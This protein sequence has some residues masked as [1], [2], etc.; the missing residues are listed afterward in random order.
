MDS[1]WTPLDLPLSADVPFSRDTVPGKM[2]GLYHLLWPRLVIC[3][4]KKKGKAFWKKG[5][6]TEWVPVPVPECLLSDVDELHLVRRKGRR[7]APRTILTK[8]AHHP[9][10]TLRDEAKTLV[11][12]ARDERCQVEYEMLRKRLGEGESLEEALK[13]TGGPGARFHTLYGETKST[14]AWARDER[15][16]VKLHT[17]HK[18]L[19]EGKSLEEAMTAAPLPTNYEDYYKRRRALKKALRKRA[20]RERAPRRPSK[21]YTLDGEAKSLSDWAEDKQCKV[22][23]ATLRNR[24][25][26]GVPLAK[27]LEGRVKLYTLDGEAKSVSAW[28]KDARCEVSAGTLRDRLN[29]G[30]CLKEALSGARRVRGRLPELFTFNGETKSLY[31]WAQDGACQVSYGTLRSRLNRGDSLARAL[32]RYDLT[33][34]A[35]V[36]NVSACVNHMAENQP[37]P[38]P[39]PT[40]AEEPKTLR[41][42]T[43]A[44]LPKKPVPRSKK[45]KPPEKEWPKPR[46]KVVRRVSTTPPLTPEQHQADWNAYLG[47]KLYKLYVQLVREHKWLPEEFESTRTPEHTHYSLP[48]LDLRR[49]FPRCTLGRGAFAGRIQI[50]EGNYWRFK[51]RPYDH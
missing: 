36:L 37:R 49:G 16:K 46:F 5:P 25:N 12:W 47:R 24:I 38:P 15:C 20:P 19:R 13:Y 14:A 10:Y 40:Q 28:A 18:R 48:L 17:L 32:K 21:L 9:I 41:V 4:K 6:G 3:R 42:G 7:G 34:D 31:D 39:E 43:K 11:E 50:S 27:A 22:C 1:Q 33:R 51:S 45:P 29:K 35:Y 2:Y 44:P 26:K 23:L 30:E 8:K